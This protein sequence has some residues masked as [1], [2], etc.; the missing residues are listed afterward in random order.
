MRF[1][2]ILLSLASV[3]NCIAEADRVEKGYIDAEEV[4]S[5]LRS[6]S[7]CTGHPDLPKVPLGACSHLRS[8][9]VCDEW[10]KAKRVTIF[11]LTTPR[12]KVTQTS[13]LRLEVVNACCCTHSPP[14]SPSRLQIK[15]PPQL[16]GPPLALVGNTLRNHPFPRKLCPHHTEHFELTARCKSETSENLLLHASWIL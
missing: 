1:L 12:S 15:R 5:M 4:Q 13:D 9:R 11:I 16:D 3:R 8:S 7:E 6:T 10:T 2:L 14:H